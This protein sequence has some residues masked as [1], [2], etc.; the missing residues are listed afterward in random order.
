MPASSLG[1]P[2]PELRPRSSQAEFLLPA[3]W[4]APM[5]ARLSQHTPNQ[6]SS[7]LASSLARASLPP[8]GCS[9]LR[10][11]SASPRQRRLI[12]WSAR[13]TNFSPTQICWL[14]GET[15]QLCALQRALVGRQDQ[16]TLRGPRR[17]WWVRRP[18]LRCSLLLTTLLL[19]FSWQHFS[20]R[21]RALLPP[22]PQPPLE[23]TITV[24]GV[25]LHPR[26]TRGP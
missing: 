17:N 2:L 21:R 8:S 24:P 11:S 13:P 5:Q 23:S 18:A 20:Q 6:I 7:S 4:S 14:L 1:R 22:I 16:P 10:K 26:A 9:L 15:N 19:R 3:T 12:G 25:V